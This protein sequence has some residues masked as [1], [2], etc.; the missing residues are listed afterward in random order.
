MGRANRK[1]VGEFGERG[2]WLTF[3]S[4]RITVTKKA[5]VYN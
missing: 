4:N 5:A 1:Y 2:G 3:K